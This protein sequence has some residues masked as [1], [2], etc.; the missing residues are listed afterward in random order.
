MQRSPFFEVQR[1]RGDKKTSL[2]GGRHGFTLIELMVVLVVIAILAGMLLPVLGSARRTAQVARVSVEIKSLEAAIA[3]FKLKYGVE[4]PSVFRLREDG[5]YNITDKLDA[6][7]VAIIR[8]L[9]PEYEITKP[10]SN[11]L[12]RKLSPPP[13]DLDG[14]SKTEFTMNGAECLVFFLG[15]PGMIYS[16]PPS[17]PGNSVSP[18]N[19]KD[20]I[21][22]GFSANPTN[23]FA[24][25]GTRVGPFFEFD[26]ARLMDL[27]GD[28]V[29]EYVDPLPGQTMPYQYFSSN[30][31]RGYRL[32]GLV[33]SSSS[34]IANDALAQFEVIP[35][36]LESVYYQTA[37][38]ISSP[39]ASSPTHTIGYWNPK[40]FQ[41]ISPGF[42]NKYG[43]GGG[44]RDKTFFDFDPDDG[45]TAPRNAPSENDNITN[46]S[47]G[48][49]VR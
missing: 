35:N 9:W 16:D 49:L 18:G 13:G 46:F 5:E 15:G 37:R 27:D 22:G 36:T 10:A 4:P 23:P 20:S 47:G 19:I 42:D 8:Q 33:D 6:E 30:G 2:A 34:P 31:G 7:S 11:P 43:T 44:Y 3:A 32:R 41:I 12:I 21:P 45:T 17:T 26:A 39:P 28:G 25:G 38:L 48:V 24:T 14:G 29:P 1:R 40:G